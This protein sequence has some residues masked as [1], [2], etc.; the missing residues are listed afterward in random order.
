MDAHL[1]A[2]IDRLQATLIAETNALKSGEGLDF[3]ESTGR[4]NQSLLELT[5][6]SRGLNHRELAQNPE[7]RLRLEG[8]RRH[9]EENRRVIE[10]HVEASREISGIIST[11]I[12]HAESDGTYSSSIGYGRRTL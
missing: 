12:T 7:M 2:A 1:N 4:K 8:L 11:S 10:L 5:R 3:D 9:I 6:M